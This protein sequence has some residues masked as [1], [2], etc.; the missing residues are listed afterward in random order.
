MTDTGV[1]W[2]V[3]GWAAHG[4]RTAPVCRSPRTAARPTDRGRRRRRAGGPARSPRGRAAVAAGRRTSSFRR[5]LRAG[6][7]RKLYQSDRLDMDMSG[8]VTSGHGCRVRALPP[9]R[10][11]PGT[12]RQRALSGA[13]TDPAATLSFRVPA[14]SRPAGRAAHPRNPMTSTLLPP[15]SDA[16]VRRTGAAGLAAALAAAAPRWLD[17]VEYRPRSRWTHLLPAD[18]G[19]RRP[20]PRPARRPGR[21]PGLAAVLAARAGHA[22][23]RPRHLGRRLQRRAGHPH[24]AG[25]RRRARPASREPPPSSP[26]AGCG[27]SAR[28][29]CTR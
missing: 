22:A 21:R 17:L 6:A 9:G 10:C 1:S 23:A 18:D 13:L 20:R 8:L 15:R 26:P 25:R 7:T 11:R 28:T 29:T 16:T 24:R 19:R 14:R 4:G 3:D 5:T 27:T 12:G 2:E